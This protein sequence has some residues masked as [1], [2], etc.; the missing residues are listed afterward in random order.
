MNELV[1]GIAILVSSATGST[2]VQPPRAAIAP[3]AMT[4]N[5]PDV[6][7]DSPRRVLR[8]SP[9]QS[10]QGTT[11]KRWDRTDRM[12]IGIL[13]G[14]LGGSL[15]GQHLG[16]AASGGGDSPGMVGALV[17]APVGALIGGMIGWHSGK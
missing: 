14:Y 11:K 15:A 9:F 4:F 1:L 10:A 2:A 6:P 7:S 16:A 3:P 5:L 12:I 13:A 8:R 17:G